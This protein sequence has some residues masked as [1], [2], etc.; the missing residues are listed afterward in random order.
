MN[1]CNKRLSYKIL[2]QKKNG[3]DRKIINNYLKKEINGHIALIK[4]PIEYPS[5][6]LMK[7]WEQ[8]LYLQ[9]IVTAFSWFPLWTPI[10]C[11]FLIEFANFSPFKQ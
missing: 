10:M 9:R 7:C 11:K 4:L 6:L 8:A 1:V 2:S 3:D 5:S